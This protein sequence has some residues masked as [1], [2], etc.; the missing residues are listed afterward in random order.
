MRTLEDIE[1]VPVSVA[2]TET[3]ADAA[4]QLL[5]APVAAIGVL[6]E[7]RR[8]VGLFGGEELLRGIFPRYLGELHHTAFAVDDP[9]VLAARAEAVR[10]DPVDKH[11]AKAIT[12]DLDASATHVGEVFLHSRF[13]ALP[14]V[15]DGVFVGMLDRVEFARA[16]M[17][18]AGTLRAR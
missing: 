2:R 3:F 14:V 6:D 15:A 10:R 18:N 1:L 11:M 5:R 12:V 7:Q 9:G 13:I 4:E 17:R 8:V 16:V